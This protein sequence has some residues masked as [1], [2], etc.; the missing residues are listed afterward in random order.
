MAKEQL[1][2]EQRKEYGLNWIFTHY[3]EPVT[4]DGRTVG[5]RLYASGGLFGEL[6]FNR[7]VWL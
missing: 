6:R 1:T 2:E 5:Y 7:Y 3:R 4:H